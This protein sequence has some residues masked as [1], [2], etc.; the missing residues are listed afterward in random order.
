MD[1]AGQSTGRREGRREEEGKKEGREQRGDGGGRDEE[2]R[3]EKR[4]G[5]V[6]LWQMFCF[7]K[8]NIKLSIQ[9]SQ[10]V[11]FLHIRKVKQT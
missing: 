8:G 11:S 2:E 6:I 4:Y 9:S 1:W 5:K 3:G 10:G 7:Q